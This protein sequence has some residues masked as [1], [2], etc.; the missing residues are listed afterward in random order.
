MKA[1]V[2]KFRS[3]QNR[4][5]KLLWFSWRDCWEKWC[6]IGTE[7]WVND[8][9]I[10]APRE[11]MG[12]LRISFHRGTLKSY[13][14]FF[15]NLEFLYKTA[16]DPGGREEQGSLRRGLVANTL[17]K[18]FGRRTS[19]LIEHR[20]N[21]SLVDGYFWTKNSH[22]AM[23]QLGGRV[24]MKGLGPLWFLRKNDGQR[25]M[26]LRSYSLPRSSQFFNQRAGIV[27]CSSFGLNSKF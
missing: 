5:W 21:A 11:S 20:T 23:R 14:R 24:H 3:N 4:F 18:F 19:P 7:W 6:R 25:V 10:R 17:S 16:G 13:I 26:F 8:T 12:I 27:I 9:R 1:K 22:C 15:P 2:P